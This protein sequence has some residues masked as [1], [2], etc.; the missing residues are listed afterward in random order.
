MWAFK[1]R[2]TFGRARKAEETDFFCEIT[3]APF[4]MGRWTVI[5]QVLVTRSI[6]QREE[7]GY[8]AYRM[9]PHE[10]L[11]V[12]EGKKCCAHHRTRLGRG[13]EGR[14]AVVFSAQVVGGMWRGREK[15]GLILQ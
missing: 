12:L 6:V 7:G 5:L 11:F 9:F 2:L 15:G 4:C 13:R 10:C 3:W 1:K 8:T 14:D